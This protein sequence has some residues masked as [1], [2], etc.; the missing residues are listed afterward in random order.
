MTDRSCD[1]DHSLA[2]TDQV[3]WTCSP[4]LTTFSISESSKKGES[5]SLDSKVKRKKS[6][7]GKSGEPCEG[8]RQ[9]TESVS[10]FGQFFVCLF[11][12]NF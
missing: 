5:P 9:M 8:K 2:E 3:Q 1:K 6:R 4:L 11:A 10:V 12:L 7:E